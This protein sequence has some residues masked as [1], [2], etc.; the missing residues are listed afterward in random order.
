MVPQTFLRQYYDFKVI[1]TKK[2]YTKLKIPQGK[3]NKAPDHNII[4]CKLTTRSQIFTAY[5][6]DGVSLPKYKL[7]EILTHFMILAID[8]M[9]VEYL[10]HEIEQCRETQ[11]SI[12]DIYSKIKTFLHKKMSEQLPM[13]KSR[14]NK[15]LKLTK[16]Y[17]SENLYSL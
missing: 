2:L 13:Y 11:D 17:W 7:K 8:I 4:Q 14:H 1:S 9:Q 5:C 15:R 6:T 12:S 10:I 16:P 3:G